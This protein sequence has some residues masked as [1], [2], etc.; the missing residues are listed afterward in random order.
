MRVVPSRFAMDIHGGIAGIIGR[1]LRSFILPT[2]ALE[3]GP[4]F[5]Q[6][7]IHGEVFVKE[8]AVDIAL[9]RRSRFL[10]HVAGDQIGSSIFSGGIA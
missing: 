4:G 1:R 8:R 5:E 2:E 3:T 7:A 9:S 6:G 10:L